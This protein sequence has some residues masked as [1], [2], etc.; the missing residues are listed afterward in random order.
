MFE[1]SFLE[2]LKKNLN[3]IKGDYCELF[4]QNEDRQV[5]HYTTDESPLVYLRKLCGISLRKEIGGKTIFKKK[6]SPD[7]NKLLHFVKSY[8]ESESK[9]IEII[10]KKFDTLKEKSLIDDFFYKKLAGKRYLYSNENVEEETLIISL[11]RISVSVI[12]N[13]GLMT[14]EERYHHTA[15]AEVKFKNGKSGAEAVMFRGVPSSYEIEKNIKYCFE[16]ACK[17]A[18]YRNSSLK[19]VSGELP[20][21]FSSRA[22]GFLLNEAV[23]HFFEADLNSK[24]LFSSLIG[25]KIAPENITI[26]DAGPIPE[27]ALFDDEGFEPLKPVVIVDKGKVVNLLTNLKSAFALSLKR[28]GNARRK[29]FRTTPVTG[30]FSLNLSPSDYDENELISR[31]PFGIYINRLE[32]GYL[33]LKKNI[34]S[35]PVSE[36]YLIREGKICEPLSGIRISQKTPHFLNEIRLIGNNPEMFGGIRVKG[37]NYYRTFEYVPSILINKIN[38]HKT[39]HL[40]RINF[41]RSI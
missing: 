31:V 13:S 14:N 1:N 21:V 7:L 26:F 6:Q 18:N 3:K 38:V 29:S 10:E 4:V 2:E 22:A 8:G 9:E 39:A 41:D 5:I 27:E 28:T 37:E 25:E 15:F 16:E 20:A 19:S 30:V 17:I 32:D 12:N 40:P 24:T 33:S 11:S 35:F 23:S 34:F 36:G